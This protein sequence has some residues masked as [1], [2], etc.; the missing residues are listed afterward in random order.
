MA[1]A[2]SHK[3]IK[4]KV[5]TLVIDGEVVN[6]IEVVASNIAIATSTMFIVVVIVKVDNFRVGMTT[7]KQEQIHSIIIHQIVVDNQHYH[8]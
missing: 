1:F 4:G 2:Y 8:T 5:T 7:V 3:E 6:I